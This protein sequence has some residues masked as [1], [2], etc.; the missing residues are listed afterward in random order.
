MR[1]E[2]GALVFKECE[3]L[4]HLRC[5][6]EPRVTSEPCCTP[7]KTSMGHV[8]DLGKVRYTLPQNQH[9]DNGN[10]RFSI[11]HREEHL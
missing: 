1:I 11:E 9:S 5:P 2:V 8:G 4:G 7:T 3:K 6:L 10:P